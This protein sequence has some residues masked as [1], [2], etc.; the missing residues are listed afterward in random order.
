MGREHIARKR[1]FGASVVLEDGLHVAPERVGCRRIDLVGRQWS[2]RQ[3]EGRE[4]EHDIG[5]Q[6]NAKDDQT[7]E[8]Q[9]D[10]AEHGAAR[11]HALL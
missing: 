10:C 5:D 6:T 3:H 7:I 1:H 4:E 11:S 8:H 2:K 9:S